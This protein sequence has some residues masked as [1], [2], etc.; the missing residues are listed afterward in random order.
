MY[1]ST[2]WL[3]RVVRIAKQFIKTVRPYKARSTFHT[4]LLYRRFLRMVAS[5]NYS[6]RV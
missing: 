2:I 5:L 4:V 3:V 6:T 1:G